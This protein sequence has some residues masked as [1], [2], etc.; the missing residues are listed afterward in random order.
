MNAAPVTTIPPLAGAR[1]VVT[2]GARGIG[3][4]IA[5]R[6]AAEGARVEI[7]DLLAPEGMSHAAEV[8]GCFH[9][10]DLANAAEARA[11]VEA[12]IECVGGID[13]LV[14]SA[15][16]F[17]L[18]PMLDIDVE[19]WDRMLDINARATL[20]TMQVAARAMRETGGNIINIASMAAKRGG[21]REAH[22]AASKAAVVV[23]TRAGAAE[24]GEYG[25]RVNAICPGYVL[26]DMG[27]ATRTQ[28]DVDAWTARSP[29][30]RLGNP[31]DVASVAL[32]L[33]TSESSYL[34]G[35]AID[36]TGGIDTD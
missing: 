20:I 17:R 34:T 3:G 26:T 22:Y 35:E 14:N 15:G 18:T 32:F 6:F 8:G 12:A 11:S 5:S 21:A 4:A 10:V 2:G 16:V 9:Q 23:L 24:W 19:E 7:L 1:V 36:V 33:A 30:R 28:A 29:L 13:I 31:G 27:A 25:I